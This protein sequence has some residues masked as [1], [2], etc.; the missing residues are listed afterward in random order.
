MEQA[1]SGQTKVDVFLD[2][3]GTPCP[4]NYVK[5]KIRMEEMEVGQIIEVILDDGE[6]IRNVPL[7]L[8]QDGHEILSQ[9]KIDDR[10]WRVL[11]RKLK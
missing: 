5:T 10:H 3:K 8:K 2:L 9:E 6:P 4:L 7:S 11:I 1:L